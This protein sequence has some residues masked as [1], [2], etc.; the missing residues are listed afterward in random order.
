MSVTYEMAEA[1]LESRLSESAVEHCRRVAQTAAALAS[2]YGV[3]PDD[4]ALAGLLHDWDREIAAEG[5]LAAADASG[6][7]TSSADKAVPYLLHAHT[8]ASA[9][10]REFPGISDEVVRAVAHH[11]VGSAEMTELD[12]VVYLADMIEPGR[13][14]PG[15]D[16]LREAVGTVSLD[17][18]FAKG[19]E[20]SVM[21][22]LRSRKFIHPQTVAVW[23]ALV[24]RGQR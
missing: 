5:L 13:D 11:T 12:M 7:P 8:G 1:A 10:A 20:Q 3:D 2:I 23:N 9:V 21:H 15:V 16:D 4:A 19:Y 14:Y 18:L 24:A 22:L 17:D 6:I